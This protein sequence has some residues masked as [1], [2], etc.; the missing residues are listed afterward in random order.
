[1][2]AIPQPSSTALNAVDAA[3]EAEQSRSPGR[4][5]LGASIIKKECERELWYVFRWALMVLHSARLLRLFNRGQLEENRFNYWLKAA[6]FQVWDVDPDTND[7]WRIEDVGGHFGGSLDGVVLGL[8]EAPDVAHVSEQK[9]HNDKSFK[10]VEKKGVLES[11]PAHYGQM[12]VYMHKMGLT[13]ALYQAINKN[14][15]DLYF[16]R[17]AYDQPEAERLLK[18]AER[19][20]VS[21]RPRERISTDASW[22]QC[23]F[24]DFHAICHGR[25]APAANCRTCVHSTPLMDGNARWFCEKSE[26]DLSPEDQKQACASHN[27][28]PP[29][30]DHFAEP[31]DTHGDNVVYL[32]KLNQKQFTNGPDGY[33]SAEIA[34][35]TDVA[36]IGDEVTDM[37]KA[38]FEGAELIG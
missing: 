6:G 17:V 34:A 1:M 23:K 11:K 15:D 12:Q 18:K 10:D 3:I 25:K 19:I 32:N 27:F 28:I 36:I 14:N 26:R 8:P 24:C 9:T 16:E 2:V 37:L 33:S 21:D 35:V 20:I 29:M 5:H 30:L 4:F 38:E 7:Q 31:L 22:Y 13:H